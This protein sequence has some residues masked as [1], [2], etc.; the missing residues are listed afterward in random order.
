M[1]ASYQSRLASCYQFVLCAES[2][3]LVSERSLF[4]HSAFVA[5]SVGFLHGSLLK[6]DAKQ[7]LV[8]SILHLHTIANRLTSHNKNRCLRLS[9]QLTLFRSHRI[10][11]LSPHHPKILSYDEANLNRTPR[12][13]KSPLPTPGTSALY[14]WCVLPPWRREVLQPAV[15]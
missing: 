2:E 4:R 7:L 3:S 12:P 13:P 14:R 10:Q 6:S 15:R 9:Q 8:S 1:L 5:N 11:E